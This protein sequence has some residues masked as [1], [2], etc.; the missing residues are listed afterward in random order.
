MNR[1]SHLWT[2][3]S[4]SEGGRGREREKGR[5]EG[6][7]GQ[8]KKKRSNIRAEREPS[9]PSKPEEQGATDGETRGENRPYERARVSFTEISSHRQT[10]FMIILTRH[11]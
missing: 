7:K 6:E 3:L 11:I 4:I 2:R 8:A 5:E 10:V 9:N 1:L